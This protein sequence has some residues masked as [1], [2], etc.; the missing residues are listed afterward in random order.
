MRPRLI[1]AAAFG[2][3]IAGALTVSALAPRA[4]PSS[5]QAK[6]TRQQQCFYA[7]NISNYTTEGD[8]IVY[9][10]VGVGD[11]YRLDLMTDCPE[12]GFRQNIEFSRADP[13][14]SICSALDLTIKFRQNGARRICPVSEMRH[15]TPTEVAALP[16]RL[17]P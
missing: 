2:V 4:E 9:L 15:L 3:A 11:I 17:R 1:S 5:A 12:L 14:S 10:R 8:R 13:G 6:D 7:S 16:K